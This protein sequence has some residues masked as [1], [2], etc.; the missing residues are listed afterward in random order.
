MPT[1]NETE[2]QT[3]INA[4]YTARDAYKEIARKTSIARVSAQF[5]QQACEAEALAVRFEEADTIAVK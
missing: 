3:I 5:I 2:R 4:L 1:L